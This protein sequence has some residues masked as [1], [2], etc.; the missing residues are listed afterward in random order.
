MPPKKKGS[1]AKQNPLAWKRDHAQDYMKN[2][3]RF[4]HRQDPIFQRVEKH[5]GHFIRHPSATDYDPETEKR[6]HA[7]YWTPKSRPGYPT[8]PPSTSP[9]EFAMKLLA[10][11]EKKD[12]EK[13]A[14]IKRL[15]A[16]LGGVH[17]AGS[18]KFKKKKKPGKKPAK[19]K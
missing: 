9:I 15:K 3:F 12:E 10:D 18:F 16:Q 14:Q 5:T 4:P 1:S 11:E 6:L 8:S 19:K 17:S 2:M 7:K 13:K